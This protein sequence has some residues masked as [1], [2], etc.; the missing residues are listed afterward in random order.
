MRQ[1]LATEK[2]GLPFP[3]SANRLCLSRKKLGEWPLTVRY[4]KK[5]DFFYPAGFGHRK[6]LQDFFVDSK[7]P[8][9]RRDF[10]PLLFAG[11]ALAWVCGYRADARF[12]P[13][14]NET[15][16]I[17]ITYTEDE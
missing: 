2:K 14:K 7:V 15:H 5:G 10:V 6:S 1:L 4:R 3:A 12:A 17:E 9:T 8:R 13:E 11:D 16:L